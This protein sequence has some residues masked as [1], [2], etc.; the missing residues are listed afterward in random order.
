[1]Q[2]PHL[3]FVVCKLQK[4]LE[5]IKTGTSNVENVDVAT[6]HNDEVLETLLRPLMATPQL[7][8]YHNMHLIE[9]IDGVIIS[10]WGYFLTA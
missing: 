5:E 3:S 4:T 8:N 7:Y 6:Y 10:I 9:C 1:M 2:N